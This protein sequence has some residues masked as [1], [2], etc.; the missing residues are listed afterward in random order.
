MVRLKDIM[1]PLSDIMMGLK[2]DMS[3]GIYR[4]R[5]RRGVKLVILAKDSGF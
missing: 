3:Y 5:E 2:K 4:M 1:V